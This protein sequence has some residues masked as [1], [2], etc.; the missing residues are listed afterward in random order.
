MCDTK[1][2]QHL[3]QPN[4]RDV[5]KCSAIGILPERASAEKPSPDAVGVRSLRDKV[6]SAFG[7]VIKPPGA[8]ATPSTEG[9]GSKDG[10][11]WLTQ[12]NRC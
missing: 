1:L 5:T 8:M 11:R 9:V 2:C 6:A 10:V 3:L 12:V 7:L 4:R